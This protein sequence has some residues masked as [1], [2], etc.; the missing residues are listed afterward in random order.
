[1]CQYRSGLPRRFHPLPIYDLLNQR[2][3]QGGN[4]PNCPRFPFVLRPPVIGSVG[5]WAVG[6]ASFQISHRAP[7]KASPLT[8][9]CSGRPGS[10]RSWAQLWRATLDPG[11]LQGGAGDVRLFGGEGSAL[12]RL[13]ASPRSGTQ[14]PTHPAPLP[15]STRL[16]PRPFLPPWPFRRTASLSGVWR[17]RLMRALGCSGDVESHLRPVRRPWPCSGQRKGQQPPSPA[18]N[19]ALQ[20]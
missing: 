4:K 13:D 3:R 7:L 8:C 18:N 19:G 9:S 5:G 1:M 2:R 15:N 14:M 16:H 6:T 20:L 12:M 11:R 10:K 17:V